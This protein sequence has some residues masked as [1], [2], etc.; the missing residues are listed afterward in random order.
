MMHDFMTPKGGS[1]GR[2]RFGK[3]KEGAVTGD[4]DL[5]VGLVY[6]R[7]TRRPTPSYL[8][9]SPVWGFPL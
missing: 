9:E 1:R 7:L 2:G 4:L 5:A 8:K 3:A 6:C